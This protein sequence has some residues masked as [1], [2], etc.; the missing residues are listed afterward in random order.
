MQEAINAW[1]KS[2]QLVPTIPEVRAR[3]AEALFDN[4]RYEEALPHLL[5]AVA[6]SPRAFPKGLYFS[7]VSLI[8]LGRLDEGVAQLRKITVG[9]PALGVAANFGHT[10]VVRALLD[11]GANVNTVWGDGRSPLLMASNFGW[12]AT[13]S[14]LCARGADVTAR[15]KGIG[16]P[17]ARENGHAGVVGLLLIAGAQE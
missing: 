8:R 14:L 2:L 5:S 15:S 10:D 3:L 7:G 1:N 13:V 6:T 16:S 11:A 12:E 4:G 17:L 9:A